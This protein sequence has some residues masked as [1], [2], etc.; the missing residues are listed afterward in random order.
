M[1]K[2]NLKQVARGLQ[3]VPASATD[4]VAHTAWVYQIVVS[5]INTA[6]VTLLVQDKATTP[7]TLVPTVS[8]AA[9]SLTIINIPGGI[10][11]TGGIRWIAGTADKLHAEIE[12]YYEPGA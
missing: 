5:N 12:A 8:L 7:L 9:N 1:D 3:V 6:A 4:V 2:K 11:M 10:K